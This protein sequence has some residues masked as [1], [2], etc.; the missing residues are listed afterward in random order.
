M[1]GQWLLDTLQK[2]TAESITAVTFKQ[3][4]ESFPVDGHLNFAE[5]ISSPT[6]FELREKG[7]LLL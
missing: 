2:V 1:I 7:L 4:E 6:W 5:F 3:L